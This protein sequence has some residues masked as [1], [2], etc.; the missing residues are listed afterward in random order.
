MY[1][2]PWLLDRFRSANPNNSNLSME[3]VGPWIYLIEVVTMGV[4]RKCTCDHDGDPSSTGKTQKQNGVVQTIM[5][6]RELE[7]SGQLLD[8]PL[9]GLNEN[10][11]NLKRVVA[12]FYGKKFPHITKLRKGILFFLQLTGS[13]RGGIKKNTYWCSSESTSFYSLDIKLLNYNFELNMYIFCCKIC[14]FIFD[15]HKLGGKLQ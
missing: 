6:V 12:P 15:R 4:E 3:V 11:Q 1:V 9:Y 2:R 7:E 10:G 8:W 14:Q 5:E 13:L